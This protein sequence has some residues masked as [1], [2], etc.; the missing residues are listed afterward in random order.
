VSISGHS[1]FAS[2]GD[3]SCIS[4]PKL[5]AVVAWRLSSIMRSA[6]QASLSPPFIFQPLA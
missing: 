5:R 1:S 6:L 4:R 2:A 3:S